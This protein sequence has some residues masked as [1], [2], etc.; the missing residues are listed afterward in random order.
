M[1]STP[2]K[3]GQ[4]PSS[5]GNTSREGSPVNTARPNR[6]NRSDAAGSR[7]TRTGAQRGA[8][9]QSDTRS[10]AGNT[11]RTSA[12]RQMGQTPRS[13]QQQSRRP[14]ARY[15][16][17]PKRDYFPILIGGAVGVGV[18][19]IMVIA[20]LLL[21]PKSTAS[22]VSPTPVGMSQSQNSG[23]SM[24]QTLAARRP[25]DG[26]GTPVA[27]EGNQHVDEGTQITYQTY[28]PSTGSHYPSTAKYGFSETPLQAG[29]FVHNLEHGSVVI[30]YKSD[31]S[32]E[33]KQQLRDTY[34][35]LPA[36]KY[37]AVKLVITPYDNM[38]TPIAIAA[39][40]RLYKMNEYNYDEIQ[41][42][43][44]TWVDKGPED[45]P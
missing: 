12:T 19:G 10:R 25:V 37:G 13:G 18:V 41:T 38:D 11:A 26:I 33:V 29:N 14:P 30:Y 2:P 22:V 34:T 27:D 15:Y 23:A 39:W 8:Q 3:R 35:R 45:I 5:Q 6:S 7:E 20:F 31:V 24:S 44:I 16:E 36:A 43:Y 9:A 42:F 40:D 1:S 32:E 17:E 28:P 21:S 4:Q